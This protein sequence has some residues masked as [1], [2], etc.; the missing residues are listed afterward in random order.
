MDFARHSS[1]PRKMGPPKG[2][3]P[4]PGGL[5]RILHVFY[6]RAPFPPSP[7][8]YPAQNAPQQ[9]WRSKRS[10]NRPFEGVRGAKAARP[11]HVPAPTVK[12]AYR[13]AGPGRGPTYDFFP[14]FP[15]AFP[16][17]GGRGTF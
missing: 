5:R 1:K 16:R 4:R 8:Y 10:N 13:P 7:A 9:P 17:N 12:P 11:L 6:R 2:W 14:S 3:L 15:P